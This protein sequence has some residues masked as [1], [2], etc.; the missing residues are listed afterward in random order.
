MWKRC[1]CIGRNA[2]PQIV[3]GVVFSRNDG[4]AWHMKDVMGDVWEF[5]HRCCMGDVKAD[6]MQNE[7]FPSTFQDL[8]YAAISISWTVLA[9]TQSQESDGV[10]TVRA[11]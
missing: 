9:S 4:L 7:T 5:V 1:G 2:K 10:S 11:I 3:T 8:F 6:C